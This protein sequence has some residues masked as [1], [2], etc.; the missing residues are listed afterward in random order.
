MNAKLPVGVLAVTL[1]AGFGFSACATESEVEPMAEEP[2][3]ETTEAVAETGEPAGPHTSAEWQLWAYSTAAP[4]FIGD[5]ATILD[6]D[7]NVLRE[8][9]NGWTCLAA[10]PRGMSDPENGWIDALEAMPLCG[11]EEGFKWI[12]AYLTGETPQLERDTYVWMLH[13]DKGEDNS[14]PFVRNQADAEDPA[15]WIESGPH[16]MLMPKDPASLDNFTSDFTTGAPYNMF[17]GTKYAHLMIPTEGYYDD[18][19]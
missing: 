2:A 3:V 9:T 8:G 18:K 13:G 5:T 1:L 16:L 15:N 7:N 11:D 4:S 12:G 10:N 17:R 19:Q 6:G 14:T